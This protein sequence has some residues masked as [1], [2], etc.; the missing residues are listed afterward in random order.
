MKSNF[1]CKNNISKIPSMEPLLILCTIII[2]A[3]FGNAFIR[4]AYVFHF[5]RTYSKINLEMDIRVW[6]TTTKYH[7]KL[8]AKDI[9]FISGNYSVFMLIANIS[10]IVIWNLLALNI[11]L[12]VR[13]F[14]ISWK[15]NKLSPST[16]MAYDLNET[17]FRTNDFILNI[18]LLIIL[19]G[20]SNASYKT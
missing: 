11:S 20:N 13:S 5:M 19:W 7:P 4:M 8:N 6:T 15:F 1:K 9:S 3:G 10:Y 16:T 17:D 14:K 2:N 18:K 12:V